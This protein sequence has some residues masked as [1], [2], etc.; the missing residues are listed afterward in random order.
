MSV[1]WEK[2]RIEFFPALKTHTYIM[3]ASASPMNKLAYKEGLDYLKTMLQHGDI[4]YELF[5]KK[6]DENRKVIAKYI[7]SKPE[8]IAFLPNV[9]SCM[10]VIARYIKKGEIIYPSVEF[11]ASIH[12]FKRLGFPNTKIIP[13]NNK[14]LLENINK[15]KSK[16]TRILIHSHVQSLTGF[17]QNLDKVG[18]FCR[19]NN[20]INI[21][22]ATQSFGSFDI[23]VKRSNID[24]LVSN[25]LKWVGCGYGAGVLYLSQELVDD[26]ELPFT[27]WLSVD[28]PF[29]M[30]NDNLN[31]INLP[32]FLDAL[33]GCPNYAAL[34][35]LKGSFTLIKDKIGRG[36]VKEGIKNIQNRIFWL[37]DLFLEKIVDFN[38]KII[39]PLELE[40]RSGIITIEHEEAERIYDFFIKNNIYVTLKKFP[41]E[42]KN[43]LLRFSF[44]YYNNERDIQK[45]IE[46]FRSYSV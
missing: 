7:N 1:D 43:T 33:G 14:Y 2:I 36:D 20:I 11:P 5:K 42:K 39:T 28:D 3:A 15:A 38:L 6:V 21:I 25:S 24:I 46:V 8:Q 23:D 16:N 31:I 29:S 34:L 4:Y 30:D 17:R 19:E 45:V 9:S 32:Q 10:N 40:Y 22:N 26:K 18:V 12:I 13:S 41:K 44:N 35:A 27:G 37:T